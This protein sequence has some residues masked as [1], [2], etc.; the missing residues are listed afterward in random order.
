MKDWLISRFGET[1]T[2]LGLFGVA[3]TFGM[4]LTQPQETAIASFA[5]LLISG[6]A[7]GHKES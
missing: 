7:I 4:Q 6:V 2:W 3:A 5:A 1:S